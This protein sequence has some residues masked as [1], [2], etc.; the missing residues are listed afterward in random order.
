MSFQKGGANLA[1]Q[2]VIYAS[3]T[4]NTVKTKLII[5]QNA[6]NK[7]ANLAFSAIIF[8]IRIFTVPAKVKRKKTIRAIFT[9]L[10]T[11]KTPSKIINKYVFSVITNSNCDKQYLLF[12]L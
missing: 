10:T 3:A 11:V 1:L 5:A 12:Y 8:S 2:F 9:L 7:L 4:R 6:G